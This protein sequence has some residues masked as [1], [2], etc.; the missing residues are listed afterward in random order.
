[1]L[2]IQRNSG[3]VKYFMEKKQHD[4]SRSQNTVEE[5][6]IHP[7]PQ[8]KSWERRMYVDWYFKETHHIHRVLEHF[9][10]FLEK[11]KNNRYFELSYSPQEF[12]KNV[13]MF[14]YK[15]SPSTHTLKHPTHQKILNTKRNS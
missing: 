5:T 1:M 10:N 8:H 6:C 14:M 2:V 11:I 3:N 9:M 4:S 13:V 7:L 15:T 12:M